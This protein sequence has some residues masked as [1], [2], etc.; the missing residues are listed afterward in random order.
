MEDFLQ[1]FMFRI[2]LH[3]NNQNVLRRTTFIILDLFH[4]NKQ[5]VH[6][7]KKIDVILW[8]YLVHTYYLPTYSKLEKM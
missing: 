6:W 8:L 3:K 5:N 7:S 2:P 4:K 1:A